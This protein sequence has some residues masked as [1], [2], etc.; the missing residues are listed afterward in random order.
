MR[1][2]EMLQEIRKMQY[3][4]VPTNPFRL[5]WGMSK[6]IREKTIAGRAWR[7][8]EIKMVRLTHARFRSAFSDLV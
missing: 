4:E 8:Q 2:T 5:K 3:E 7:L 6:Q 1:S